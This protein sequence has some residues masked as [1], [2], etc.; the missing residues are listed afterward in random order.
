MTTQS[1]REPSQL[2]TP[3]R[4]KIED[5]KDRL[6]LSSRF[7]PTLQSQQ[8]QVMKSPDRFYVFQFFYLSAPCRL[9]HTMLL[10]FT[11]GFWSRRLPPVTVPSTSVI[12]DP[13]SLHPTPLRGGMFLR[14]CDPTPC[15]ALMAPVSNHV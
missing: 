8:K 9:S 7:V 6:R 10:V 12:F 13:R 11:F 4:I 5:D 2:S 15:V 3:H 14:V 1:D